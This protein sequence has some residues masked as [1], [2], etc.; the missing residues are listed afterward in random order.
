MNGDD[1]RRMELYHP[2]ST[3][4][5]EEIV[6]R[7]KIICDIMSISKGICMTFM[8]LGAVIVAYVSTRFMGLTGFYIAF[9]GIMLDVTLGALMAYNLGNKFQKLYTEKVIN[10]YNNSIIN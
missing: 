7:K 5:T 10:E 8:I 4:P 2:E 3:L 1:R 9:F 6:R